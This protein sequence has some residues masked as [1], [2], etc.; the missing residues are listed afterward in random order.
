MS[1]TPPHG[2]RR[3]LP[4]SDA[5]RNHVLADTNIGALLWRLSIPAT[6]GMMVMATYNLVD[7]IFIGRGVGSLGI[8][9]LAVVFPLQLL[10]LAIGQFI[11]MG[12]A[13]IISR[14][15]GSGD[16]KK[17]QRAF[18]N[19][20]TLV[21]V[22]S[23]VI[24]AAG[25]GFLDEI[26]RVFGATEAIMPYA[27]DYMSIILW[28][29]AFRCYAISHNNIIRSEG[30]AKVAM[31]TMFVGAVVNIILDPIF[32]F[33]LGMGMKGAAVATVIAQTCSTAYIALY[34][35]S[36]RSCL[37]ARLAD[38]RLSLPIVRE[39]LA[40]GAASLGRMM[41]G[42]VLV[43]VLNHSLGYYGGN[44]AI[45]AFGII[46]RLL[47]F[48]FMPIVGFGQALQPVAGFNYGARRYSMVRQ[49]LR[50]SVTRSTVFSFGA[51]AVLMFL[52]RPLVGFFTSDGELIAMAVPML[53]VVAAA[54]PVVGVQMM[55]AVLFQALGHAAQALFLTLSR[56]VIFLIPLVLVL[57]RFIGFDGISWSFPA[58]DILATVVT[59]AMLA[60]EFSRLRRV[61]AQANPEGQGF[62]G[63]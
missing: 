6:V 36:G 43:I 38:L 20:L 51:F 42:S 4:S 7:A 34:F 47:Q 58:A 12:G 10:T 40:V 62:P 32:I 46:H 50:T 56:Q 48:M 60:R 22:A 31:L 17:A 61:E 15:L 29:T 23:A 41:A 11:G 44:L 30:R 28:G 63:S 52:A 26:L 8:G 33:G 5:P 9:G 3:E 24:T 2:E 57:P 59:L 16:E 25:F 39:T 19:V 27:R 1:R 54:F 37:R 21:L 45:A 14:A 35:A 18:G 53:R 13:S 49:S 55:G